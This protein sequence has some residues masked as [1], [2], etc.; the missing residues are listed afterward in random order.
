ML[1]VFISKNKKQKKLELKQKE[2]REKKFCKFPSP[3]IC[4]VYQRNT[5]QSIPSLYVFSHV[6]LNVNKCSQK[7]EKQSVQCL[8]VLSF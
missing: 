5:E 2:K 4:S 7:N 1:Y 6:F 3:K 8:V